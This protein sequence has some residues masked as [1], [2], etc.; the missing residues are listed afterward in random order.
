M[1]IRL[2]SRTMLA[3]AAAAMLVASPAAAAP[4]RQLLVAPSN[5]YWTL[6]TDRGRDSPS[7]CRLGL[8]PAQIPACASTHWAPPLG[9]DVEAHVW[10]GMKDA[11]LG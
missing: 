4:P 5:P 9:P 3:V 10:P 11:G 7:P 1:S 2:F 6:L 8:P